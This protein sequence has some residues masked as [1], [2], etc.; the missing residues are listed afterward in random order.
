MSKNM[1]NQLDLNLLKIFK[2]IAEERKTVTAAKRL[3]MTQ[4]AVSRALRRLR[5]HFDDELFVRTR[6]GLK[7]TEKGEILCQGLP[8]IF[9]QLSTLVAELSPF[10]PFN[11]HAI[12]KIA[13]NPFMTYSLVERLHQTLSQLAPNITL[14]LENWDEQSINRLVSGELDLAINYQIPIT[15]KGI[16]TT[17]IAEDS[18]QI[19]ARKDHPLSKQACNI[20]KLQRYPLAIYLVPGW[21][22]KNLLIEQF[23]KSKGYETSVS[24]RSQSVSTILNILKNSDCICPTSKFLNI[25]DL[26]YL[27][28]LDVDRSEFN[29]SG[30]ILYY[31]HNSHQKSHYHQWV[32]SIIC[33]IMISLQQ[34]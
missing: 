3:N 24:I 14:H 2:V 10:D 16:I 13:L 1:L 20:S 21:N 17:K 32:K 18:Y 31:Q 26:D 23:Y 5:D 15:I 22:G 30:D 29:T 25:E 11:H 4:P 28:L 9:D 7:P 33:E 34:Y 27:T 6:H 12:L 19:I 8:I